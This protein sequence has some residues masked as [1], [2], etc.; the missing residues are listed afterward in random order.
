MGSRLHGVDDEPELPG[1]AVVIQV[2]HVDR[3]GRCSNCCGRVNAVLEGR[4]VNLH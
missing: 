4:G 1:R 2:C 3:M